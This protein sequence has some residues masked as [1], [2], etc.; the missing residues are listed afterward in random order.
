MKSH[1]LFN[2]LASLIQFS[3]IACKRMNCF[4]LS[5]IFQWHVPDSTQDIRH[6]SSSQGVAALLQA[7]MIYSMVTYLWF[8]LVCFDLGGFF[9]PLLSKT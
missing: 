3:E 5:P 2:I 6:L 1:D 9:W 8:V 4:C 7:L